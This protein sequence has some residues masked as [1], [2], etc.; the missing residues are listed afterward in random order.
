[1]NGDIDEAPLSIE[2]DDTVLS[3]NLKKCLSW[4][5]VFCGKWLWDY[6]TVCVLNGGDRPG[7][8]SVDYFRD[9]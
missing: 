7:G 8:S 1:M 9:N 3:F 5:V 6:L 2:Q 4:F